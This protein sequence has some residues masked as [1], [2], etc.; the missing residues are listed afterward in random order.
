MPVP[1]VF[2][3]AMG[4]AATL[5]PVHQLGEQKNAKQKRAERE[6]REANAKGKSAKLRIKSRVHK[7][8]NN[9]ERGHRAIIANW[10]VEDGQRDGEL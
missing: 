2:V 10:H 1:V 8:T 7:R 5:P 3:Q 4:F 9:L 6:E